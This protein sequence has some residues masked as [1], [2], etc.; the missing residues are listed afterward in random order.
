MAK[1]ASGRVFPPLCV[2][3][4]SLSLS[5]SLYL[6][7]PGAAMQNLTLQH[8][9]ELARE[10]SESLRV[11]ETEIEAAE[12]RAREAL[13]GALPRLNV[14]FTETLQDTRGVDEGDEGRDG[15]IR[16]DRPE[17]RL[18]LSQPLF[19]GFREFRTVSSLAA[20]REGEQWRYQRASRLL[21]LDVARAFY[22]VVLLETDLTDVRAVVD[23]SRTRVK[24]LGER[25]RLGKSRESELLSAESQL[26]ALQAEEAET[27]GDLAA[28]REALSFLTGK[29][30]GTAPL[31]D[32]VPRVEKAE[33]LDPLLARSATRTDVRAQRADVESRRDAVRVARG[34]YFPSAGVAGSYY[35]KRTGIQEP[36]DWDVIF[37]LDMPIYQGGSAAARTKQARAALQQAELELARLERG[38]STEV[39]TAHAAL[40]RSVARSA[41]LERAAE[42]AERS[43]R[44]LARE[45]R[46]GL[47][48]N[49]E[50]LQG[51]DAYTRT[52][53]DFHQAVIQGKLDWLQLKVAAEELP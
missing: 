30:L 23:L 33:P 51:L 53:R 43:Y 9:F 28:A 45:Y 48:N 47:A 18:R 11:Q 13:G 7:A 32:S 22:S 20:T 31:E 2:L 42:K 6:S 40:E 5:L 17:A 25:V 14:L 38:V 49:L 26:A 36:V 37:S 50:L 16:R 41:S 1:K 4:P 15:N 27:L 52:R 24:E 29:D 19:S 35:L 39:R 8:C 46:L 21:F 3:V 12:A 10:Q 44:L 34:A